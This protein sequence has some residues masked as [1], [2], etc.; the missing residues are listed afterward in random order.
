MAKD[1]LVF[2]PQIPM[3]WNGTE[4]VQAFDL[5]PAEDWGKIVYLVS[6][7][8]T[9]WTDSVIEEIRKKIECE[10]HPDRDYFLPLGHPALVSVAAM[11]IA[12]VAQGRNVALLHWVGRRKDYA[13]IEMSLPD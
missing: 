2:I 10:F 13:V 5:S 11:C 3:R 1:S 4:F 7:V 8:A 9:A 12:K 6:P